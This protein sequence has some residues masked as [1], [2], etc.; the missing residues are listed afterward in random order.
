MTVTG[1]GKRVT[2]GLLLRLTMTPP[3]GAFPVST[4]VPVVICPDPTFE[5]AK[6]SGFVTTGGITVR[7][8]PE[9]VPL[10]SVAVTVTGVLTATG[11]VL[12]LK[13]PLVA[14][15]TMLK[16][17]L[18]GTIAA[19][20]LLLISETVKPA[21]GAGPLRTTVPV[22][23]LPPVTEPGLNVNMEMP[24]GFTVKV[25][26][27]LL[28][29]RVAVTMTL[30]AMATPAVMA[31]NI[32][33][34]F[35]AGT[36]TVIGT[37]TAGSGL[38]KET[39]IPPAGAVWP[40]VTVPVEFVPPVT[41][42]G[43]KL[44]A[45]T[46]IEGSTVALPVTIVAPVFA[47]TV[48]GVELPTAPAVTVK[49]VLFAFAG[50]STIPLMGTGNAAELLLVRL[51]ASPPVGA[52]PDS[53]TVPVLICPETT[54]T[55][56]KDNEVTTGAFTVNMAGIAAPLGRVA[57]MLGVVLELTGD[58]VTVN[59]PLLALP[60]IV[61]LPLAGTA[62][63]AGLLL[64]SVTV[65]PAGGAGPVRTKVPV[66]FVP[67]V[68]ELGL[69]VNDM[70]A[71][72]FTVSMALA[73]LVARVACT[74]TGGL[75]VVATPTVFAVNV[76]DDCPAAIVTLGGTMTMDGTELVRK[77]VT[78]PAGAGWLSVTV[79]VELVPPVTVVRLKVSVDTVS[80]GATVTL[81]M[82]EFAPVVAVTVAL[83][84]AP[85]VTTKV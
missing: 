38:L 12:T 9:A 44:K 48:T 31:V 37:V 47:V 84:T 85:A 33:D 29:A 4:T 11:E 30:S 25:P 71:A 62:A 51:T 77:T 78:P 16:L 58:V 28:A 72:G 22:D 10:G 24:A 15:P 39:M 43:L 66:T 3:V 68:T 50:T 55:G 80:A 70:I 52:G 83:P 13:V 23:M 8:P 59:V 53:V 79:P 69:R 17:P 21:A 19:L 56:M 64:I 18:T 57:M 74:I 81:A 40:I 34:V 27:A 20:V 2:V 7:P 45:V 32:T 65:K 46:V 36:V 5:G 54:F 35:P 76:C 60:A 73:L 49:V 26:F 82:T 41:G 6:D 14:P 1:E 63:A 42:V 61:K 75:V 67:P